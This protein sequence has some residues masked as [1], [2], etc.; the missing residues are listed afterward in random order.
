MRAGEADPTGVVFISARFWVIQRDGKA[1]FVQLT[2]DGELEWSP[3]AAPGLVAEDGVV[4]INP[5][6]SLSLA[7]SDFLILRPLVNKY[8]KLFAQ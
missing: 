8:R 3:I 6:R 1:C 5:K 4:H 2:G 7:D